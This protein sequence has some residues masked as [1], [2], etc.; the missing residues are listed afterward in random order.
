MDF[1][2]D[3]FS[4]RRI[5]EELMRGPYFKRLPKL[6]GD[7]GIGSHNTWL[8]LL[9]GCP[10]PERIAAALIKLGRE[11]L[12]SASRRKCQVVNP[13]LYD[14]DAS[15]RSNMLLGPILD[16]HA[17]PSPAEI[18]PVPT[19]LWGVSLDSPVG[20][21]ASPLTANSRWIGL[22]WR[23]GAS[24]VTLKTRRTRAT[25]ACIAER[26][27]GYVVEPSSLLTE[28]PP[29]LLPSQ[30]VVSDH[31][32]RALEPG[33]P[34]VLINCFGMPSEAPEEW[35]RDVACTVHAMPAGKMLMASIVGSVS[36][37]D[38]KASN[39]REI[40]V[41]DYVA[42]V[43][44]VLTLKD[45]HLPRAVEVNVSCPN[46]DTH[47]HAVY[48]SIDMITQICGQARKMI[49][50]SGRDLKLVLKIHY[51]TRPQLQRLCDR[52]ADFVDGYA[53]INT[54]QVKALRRAGDR[55]LPY[56]GDRPTGGLSGIAIRGLAIDTIANLRGI[57]KKG[58]HGD[59][60]IFGMGGI[61]TPEDA[62]AFLEHGA[63]IVQA[64]TAVMHDSFFLAKVRRH[65]AAQLGLERNF[66]ERWGPNEQTIWSEV[67]RH[68]A[69]QAFL[70]GER[71]HAALSGGDAKKAIVELFQAWIDQWNA[72]P[73]RARA[74]PLTEDAPLLRR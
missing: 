54:L 31:G 19:E 35:L 20:M 13:P 3:G 24:V 58:G 37:A 4:V 70:N 32:W 11:V 15:F 34:V 5:G 50:K 74:R 48:E 53:A 72:E 55:L 7:A 23:L 68:P 25:P 69:V 1:R 18:A 43:G 8:R 47:E 30:V 57:L 64:T 27:I 61:T 59:K 40:L 45:A 44:N 51:M 14:T 66:V 21:S 16:A 60:P 17:I 71:A 29:G 38:E 10:V 73:G 22:D 46:T 41:E 42:C 56:F 6:K 12:D 63:T 33:Q 9:E 49:N 65:L 2:F 39:A 36:A 52:T 26:N 67:R 28:I 62:A